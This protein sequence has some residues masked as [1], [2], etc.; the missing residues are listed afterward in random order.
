MA[1]HMGRPVPLRR[2]PPAQLQGAPGRQL[3][4]RPQPHRLHTRT[5]R[6]RHTLPRARRVLHLHAARRPLRRTQRAEGSPRHSLQARR[7]DARHRRGHAPLRRHTR[8]H[9]LQGQ[10]AR[11]MGTLHQGPRPHIV[12][13]Q[14]HKQPQGRHGRKGRGARTARG[15]QGP[16]LGGRQERVRAPGRPRRHA[17]WL[18]RP[19]RQAHG[20]P[21][22]VRPQ[23]LLPVRR[24]PRMGVDGGQ[25]QRAVPPGAGRGGLRRHPL[26]GRQ[27]HGR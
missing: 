1:V 2:L 3:P 10:A 23:R 12:R 15:Q 27:P 24:Q 9:T 19:Y 14:A 21:H 26:Q 22:T 18:R 25:G 16:A 8:A 4:A 7:R 17:H 11:R 13:G 5:A 6:G 20:A